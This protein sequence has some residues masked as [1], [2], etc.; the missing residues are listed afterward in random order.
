MSEVMAMLYSASAMASLFFF[1]IF[2]I[3]IKN[4]YTTVSLHI[5]TV[6]CMECRR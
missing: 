5:S 4:L 3:L 1:I 2:A 6:C